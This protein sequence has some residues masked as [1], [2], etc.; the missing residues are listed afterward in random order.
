M[1]WTVSACAI[2]ALLVSAAASLA[3]PAGSPPTGGASTGAPAS[4]APGP[5]I[6]IPPPNGK[7]VDVKGMAQLIDS[8]I[9]L[10]LQVFPDDDAVAAKAA[11][12]NYAPLSQE[13]L[14][15]FLGDDPGRGWSFRHGD[16]PVV[17]TLEQPPFHTCTVRAMMPTEPDVSTLTALAVGVWGASQTPPVAMVAQP[18]QSFSQNGLTQDAYQFVMVDAN[19]R[20]L[21]SIGAFLTH[22][23]DREPVEVRLVRM[24]GNN[25]R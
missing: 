9:G 23:P 25:P 14:K 16:L 10:C 17:A 7:P 19:R 1:R 6:A 20:T 5:N 21:E 4:K 8:F 11:Q 18:L 3:Q 12:Q 13:Q 2:V 24:R 22:F 15:R